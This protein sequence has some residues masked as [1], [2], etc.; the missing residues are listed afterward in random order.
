MKKLNFKSL[1]FLINLIVRTP[2]SIF[3][4]LFGFLPLVF[5][6][7]VLSEPKD[8]ESFPIVTSYIRNDSESIVFTLNR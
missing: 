3:T 4:F 8:A 6:I 1:Y 7:S 5:I 2:L